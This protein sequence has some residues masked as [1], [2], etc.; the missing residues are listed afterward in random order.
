MTKSKFNYFFYVFLSLNF[1]YFITLEKKIYSLDLTID[2]PN[3]MGKKF[4]SKL[5]KSEQIPNS[6]LLQTQPIKDVSF[7]K[8]ENQINLSNYQNSILNSSNYFPELSCLKDNINFWE[9]VYSDVDTNKAIVHDRNNLAR[10]YEIVDSPKNSK[11]REL[12]FLKVKRQLANELIL[13]ANKIRS[14]SPLSKTEKNL[15]HFFS[16]DELSYTSIL[17][18]SKNIRIQTGLKSQFSAGI[19]RSLQHLQVVFPIIK[20]SG[21]PIDLIYLP[22]VESSYNPIAGSKVGALGLWQ[23]MP[24][25]MKSLEGKRAVNKRTDAFLSTQAA[26][27]L[28]KSNYEKTGS[29]PLALTAYNHGVNGVERAIQITNSKDLCK[30]IDRYDSPSFKFASTNFYAQFLAAKRVASQKYLSLATSR[31]M[32]KNSQNLLTAIGG[33]LK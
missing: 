2:L 25:T 23:L 24:S 21:L 9:K 29:W 7:T 19:K 33:N 11:N 30:I 26:M 6:P 14:N 27:K 16:K 13:L 17:E 15:T 31:S 10:I 3:D 32:K 12:Y 18:A 8:S 5:Q 1:C 20:K 4:V 22:H 28:L